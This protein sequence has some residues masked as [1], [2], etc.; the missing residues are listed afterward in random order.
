MEIYDLWK[1]RDGKLLTRRTFNDRDA[2]LAA[3][4]ELVG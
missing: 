2:A 1:L 4:G 3:V